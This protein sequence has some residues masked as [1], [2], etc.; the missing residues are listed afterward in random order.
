MCGMWHVAHCAT[1][2]PALHPTQYPAITS[3]QTYHLLSDLP[4]TPLANLPPR[5]STDP[6]IPVSMHPSPWTLSSMQPHDHHL[7]VPSSHKR[8]QG[9]YSAP[10]EIGIEIGIGIGIEIEIGIEIAVMRVCARR[11]RARSEASTH[12]LGTGLS[13]VAEGTARERD[14][15]TPATCPHLTK[16]RRVGPLNK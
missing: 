12:V 3:L 15:H 8:V 14:A 6:Y 16:S 7:A 1:T 4:T 10:P 2:T 13:Q 9:R 5:F 11:M